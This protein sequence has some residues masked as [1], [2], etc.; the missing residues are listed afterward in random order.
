MQTLNYGVIGNCTSAGLVSETGSLDWCCL[1]H[2]AAPSTF[3]KILEN[4]GGSFHIETDDDYTITQ[5]YVLDTNILMTR[6]ESGNDCF[7]VYDFMP[8]YRT[9]ERDYYMPPDVIRYVK[10]I[11]GS[12]K[13]RFVYNPQLNYALP[14]TTT[15]KTDDYIKSYI[16]NERYESIYLYTDINFDTLLNQESIT[17]DKDVFF[18]MSYNEKLLKQDIDRIRLKFE[19]TKV[20]WLNWVSRI[21]KYKKYD[22]RITR[23]ALILKLLT[24]QETGAVLAA[25]TTSLP[26]TIGEVRNWDYR[27]CW[28][29]D[30]SMIVRVLKSINCLSTAKR[31]L[32]FVIDIIPNKAEKNPDYVRH[33]WRKT[34]D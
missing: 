17:I 4:K 21:P 18:L 22:E 28:I 13:V 32:E 14:G 26:E 10:W 2:F 19:R 9:P 1:P 30:A 3:A 31:F 29:R 7:E 6:F 33:S 23:S 5:S 34:T 25:L 20:Y 15:Y 11:S 24:Y 16:D 8:R 27:F 12:S